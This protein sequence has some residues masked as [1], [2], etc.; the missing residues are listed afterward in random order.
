MHF[1]LLA[2]LGERLFPVWIVGLLIGAT[3]LLQLLLDVPAGYALDRFGYRR[4]LK[5]TTVAFI[6]ATACLLFGLHVYTYI[7]TLIL[8]TFGWLFF[9]P[10]VNAYVLATAP[11]SRTGRFISARDT[12][13]SVGIVLSSA[14][15]TFVL[16]F[17][18]P[19]IGAIL[20]SL[21]FI[22]YLCISY[23]PKE[24]AR[25]DNLKRSIGHRLAFHDLMQNM[26]KLNPASTM[27]V[28]LGLSASIFYGV[29]WFTIPIVIAHTQGWS[30]LG[31]GLGVFDFSV[32]V[33]G[34]TIG[35][36]TDTFD[37]RAL[38]FF[39]L[40]LFGLAGSIVG[41]HLG[42]FFLLFGFLATTGEEIAGITL[43]SWLHALDE[44]HAR[45]GSISGVINLFQDLGWAIGPVIAGFA[46]YS[47]GPSLTILL[48]A[49]PILVVWVVYHL[50]IGWHQMTPRAMVLALRPAMRR[51]KK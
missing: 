36:L 39:G 19:L 45:D 21:L 46:Y 14:C 1:S 34:F 27:L 17:P 49:I 48:G 4:L 28:L 7:A 40:L 37:R 3:A 5:L 16:G 30:P 47:L 18:T 26:R 10:G 44:D 22:A 2:P 42:W 50:F 8:A 20:I 12:F 9:G 23:A 31:I 25:Q 32:V 33:L 41:F 38:V 43:W 11:R 15:L 13:E 6:G 51:H 24:L 35:K 29:I